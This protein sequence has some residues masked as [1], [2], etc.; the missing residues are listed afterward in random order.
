M[1]PLVSSVVL[2]IV[3]VASFSHAQESVAPPASSAGMPT[4]R[5]T[6]P[7]GRA[8]APATVRIVAQIQW[9]SDGE[10][11]GRPLHVRFLVDGAVV[12]TVDSGPPYAVTWA[13]ENPF[14]PRDIA[15]EAAD[16]NGAIVRDKVV[17]PAYEIADATEV[18]SIAIDAAVYD[19]AGHAVSTLQQSAFTV[20]END[21]PQAVDLFTRETLPSTIGLLID[22]SQ[23]MAQRMPA[24]REAAKLFAESLGKRDKI[25]VAPF[26]HRI[27][28]ITG[29]TDDVNTTIE[30]IGT[31]KAGGGTAILN[32]LDQMAN[33]LHGVEGRRAIILI[34]DGF[35]ENST[36]DLQ[37]AIQKVQSEQITVYT[38]AMGGITGVSLHGEGTFRKLTEGTGGRAFFPWREVDL[39]SVAREVANDENSRYLITYTPAN[40]TKDGTWRAI[41]LDVPKGYHARARAGYRAA[42]PPPV[43]PQIEFRVTDNLRKYVD[44]TADDIDVVEDGVRQSIDTFQEAVDPVS[45]SLLLDAS[46]SMTRSAEVV[47]D[48]AREFVKAVRPEDSLSMITFADQPLVEH[49]L[50]TNRQ[51]TFDA[52]DKYKPAGGTALYDALWGALQQL[53]KVAGRR[54]IVVLTDGRD[55]NNAGNGPGSGHSFEEVLELSREVGATIFPIGLGTRVDKEFLEHLAKVTGGDPYFSADP[56]QLAEQFQGIVEN[57]RQRYILS[58]TSTN[59]KHDGSWRNVQVRPRASS[60]VVTTSGG[61]FAPNP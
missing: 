24:V 37:T 40:Q 52:I 53:R 42:L 18:A 51:F 1:K 17:L 49:T 10:G 32:A 16:D 5:I 45:I 25:V 8:G 59:T 23:S 13:D 36:I 26:N 39:L 47:R 61:Y 44:I 56:A 31:I 19:D 9:P 14:E 2:L 43:R 12:G 3:L 20:R 57:L 34:T 55:E 38:V 4:L 28:A 11:R 33:L 41:T 35:D 6:S 60:L 50:G 21:D 58:Y 46:G 15:V 29:P 7:L 48:T 54:A 30:A 22:S 27:G